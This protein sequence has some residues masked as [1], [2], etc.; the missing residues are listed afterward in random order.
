M[1]RRK[2]IVF[3]AALLLLLVIGWL[4]WAN[5]ALEVNTYVV[6]GDIPAAFD[7]YRIAQISDLH[8]ARMG[9]DNQKLLDALR[10]AQPDMIAITGD[11]VDARRT[12]MD[13]ALEFIQE[14]VTIA[15][16][17][18][19]TGNHE[20]RIAEYPQL[21]AAMIAA[22]VTVL[23]DE[24]IQITRNGAS[25]TL[26][27]VQDPGFD[28][29][30]EEDDAVISRRLREACLTEDDFVILLSHRPELL[31][32]YADFSIDLVFSGHAHGGQVRLPFVGGVVAPNQGLF[33]EYD[34][35]AYI[36]NGT[37]MIVS[38]GVGNSLFPLRVNNRPEVVLA[39]LQC[40]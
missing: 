38:R 40:N 21:K 4:V 18:Y 33:P 11:L 5:K 16:C 1:K 23:E 2:W 14:A 37:Q 15:P 10:E 8:N 19:V 35:G 27:G 29:T 7:G 36:E 9:K 20:N 39:E 28:T 17:Y 6:S 34:G 12:D 26:L 32:T 24:K 3:S 25:V 30:D 31:Q 13:R 22:G